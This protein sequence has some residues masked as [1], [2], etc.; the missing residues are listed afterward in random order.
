VIEPRM[1]RRRFGAERRPRSDETG[2]EHRRDETTQTHRAK[3][4]TTC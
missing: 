4:T 3:L 1:F 2:D